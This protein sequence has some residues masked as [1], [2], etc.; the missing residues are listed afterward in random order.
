MELCKV[1]KKP[2]IKISNSTIFILIP[3]KFSA[4]WSF[5]S[6]FLR[7]CLAKK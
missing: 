5:P 7:H 4:Y 1:S 6:L 3:Q 2:K